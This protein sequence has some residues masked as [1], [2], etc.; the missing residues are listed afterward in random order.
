MW[1]SEETRTLP[2]CTALSFNKHAEVPHPLRSL[3]TRA[4]PPRLSKT[5]VKF[6][7]PPARELETTQLSFLSSVSVQGAAVDPGSTSS[8]VL[9]EG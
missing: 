1:F 5:F 2:F 6:Y 4:W 7:S 3:H 8:L 9:M